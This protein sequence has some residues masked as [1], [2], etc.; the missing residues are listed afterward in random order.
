MPPEMKDIFYITTS[1]WA[2]AMFTHQWKLHSNHAVEG[3]AWELILI[4]IGPDIDT[5]SLWS[6]Q[7]TELPIACW[8]RC[9]PSL[10]SRGPSTLQSARMPCLEHG[11]TEAPLFGC[12]AAPSRAYA[13]AISP[14]VQ[15]RPNLEQ[16]TIVNKTF[17]P[18]FHCWHLPISLVGKYSPVLNEPKT[19]TREFGQSDRTAVSIRATTSTRV[20]CSVG[21]GIMC[22]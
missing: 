1:V 8:T 9:Q 20:A 17:Q 15:S 22:A 11:S 14:N 12:W 5:C 2:T 3:T 6:A 21:V 18:S 13:V 10:A 4:S 19:S 16:K 7:R